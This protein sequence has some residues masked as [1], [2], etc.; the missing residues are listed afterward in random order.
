MTQTLALRTQ[1]PTPIDNERRISISAPEQQQRRG[2]YF[3]QQLLRFSLVG[4]LNTAIDLL[5]LNGL[6]WF[7]PTHITL[8]LMGFNTIAYTVGAINSFLCNK[9]WTFRRHEPITFREVS[10]F[11]LTTLFG[12]A[13][14]DA[15]LWIV[16]TIL[17]PTLLSATLWANLSKLCAIGGTV[18]ISYLGMRLWVFV[19]TPP[20]AQ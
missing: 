10:R 13:C 7:W 9:Y 16:G 1:T 5:I 3:F 18:L 14:N 19:H 11:A 17:H 12:I 8:L 4:G 2:R 15:I 20:E 6:L